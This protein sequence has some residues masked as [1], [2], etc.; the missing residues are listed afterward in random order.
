MNHANDTTS[1]KRKQTDDWCA[2][3]KKFHSRPAPRHSEDV[4]RARS[5]HIG[6]TLG[7][8]L[9]KNPGMPSLQAFKL[10][11]LLT[12]KHADPV[13]GYPPPMYPDTAA[14]IAALPPFKAPSTEPW[15]F[16]YPDNVERQRPD[17]VEH[18]RPARPD[19]PEL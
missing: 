19:S 10:S 2:A 13:T 6:T 18:E 16:G 4:E 8:I 17:K 14:A 7:S 11:I 15:A 12:M 9:S 3:H 5:A 1:T